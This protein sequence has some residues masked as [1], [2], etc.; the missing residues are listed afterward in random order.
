MSR[1]KSPCRECDG[2]SQTCHAECAA[3]A[4]Y[5]EENEA[6]KQLIRENKRKSY[7]RGERITD[8]QFAARRLSMKSRVLKQHKK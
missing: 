1:P 5:M 4:A 6:Y 2:H 7:G 3:Y 8:K